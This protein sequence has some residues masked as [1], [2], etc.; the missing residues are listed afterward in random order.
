[1]A[2]S[3]R[4]SSADHHVDHHDHDPGQLVRSQQLVFVLRD[5]QQSSGQRTSGHRKPGARDPGCRERGHHGGGA[6]VRA[7]VRT[8]VMTTTFNDGPCKP[9]YP[10]TPGHVPALPGRRALAFLDG[11]G[12]GHRRREHEHRRLA[13]QPLPRGRE[14][15]RRGRSLLLNDVVNDVV[16]S[17]SRPRRCSATATTRPTGSSRSTAHRARHRQPRRRS[18]GADHPARRPQ[19][20]AFPDLHGVS[21][22][23]SAEEPTVVRE[24]AD[25]C[26]E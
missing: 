17:M 12:A 21:D 14:A 9:E 5:Q 1:M 3:S 13:G 7:R 22:D 8:I 6:L 16:P 23:R 18:R 2:R 4:S 10:A 24:E 15:Q 20:C 11:T 19:P 25:H 26:A